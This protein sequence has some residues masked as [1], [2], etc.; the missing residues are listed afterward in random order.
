LRILENIFA[1]VFNYY[2]SARRDMTKGRKAMA[3][4]FPEPEKGGRGKGAKAERRRKPPG[5]LIAA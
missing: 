2:Y 3:F 1:R 5:F 4:H